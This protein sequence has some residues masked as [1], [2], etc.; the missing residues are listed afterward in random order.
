M[1]KDI[2]ASVNEVLIKQKWISIIL[3]LVLPLIISPI[4]VLFINKASSIFGKYDI[5]PFGFW[6]LFCVLV[7]FSFLFTS[8]KNNAVLIGAIY[9]PVMFCLLAV[10]VFVFPSIVKGVGF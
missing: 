1:I 10:Y 9:I 5:I 6:I 8:Y 3:C 7:G 2:V 4:Y